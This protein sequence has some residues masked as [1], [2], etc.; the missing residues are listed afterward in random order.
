MAIRQS[1]WNPKKTVTDIE[2]K[3]LNSPQKI[4][5]AENYLRSWPTWNDNGAKRLN[6]TENMEGI[7]PIKKKR[8]VTVNELLNYRTKKR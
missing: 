7:A 8:N 6:D 3:R 4:E 1:G 2:K 5:N